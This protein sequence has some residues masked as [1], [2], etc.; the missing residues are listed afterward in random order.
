M[1]NIFNQ[2][3]TSFIFCEVYYK[4]A[5]SFV[6][7]FLEPE[8]TVVELCRSKG[9]YKFFREV[10]HNKLKPILNRRRR[11]LTIFSKRFDRCGKESLHHFIKFTYRYRLV[12]TFDVNE[13]E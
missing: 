13:K 10:F 1:V 12:N 8:S 2:F 6:I 11:I 5:G 3:I 4:M 9:F 7:F